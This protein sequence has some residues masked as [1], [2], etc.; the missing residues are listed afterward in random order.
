MLPDVPP[1]RKSSVSTQHR[2]MLAEVTLL[3]WRLVCLNAYNLAD[4]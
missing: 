1:P 3:D 4:A 2:F